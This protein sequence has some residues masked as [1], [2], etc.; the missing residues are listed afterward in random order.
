MEAGL[1]VDPGAA[2]IGVDEDCRSFQSRPSW[3]A[4]SV[5]RNQRCL[6]LRESA[7]KESSVRLRYDENRN[8]ALSPQKEI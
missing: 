8:P 6:S 7:I 5:T 4:R 1:A 2:N 3:T